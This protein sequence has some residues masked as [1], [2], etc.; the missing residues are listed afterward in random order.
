MAARSCVCGVALFRLHLRRA[1]VSALICGLDGIRGFL[2]GLPR[3]LFSSRG[4]YGTSAGCGVSISFSSHFP[5]THSTRRLRNVFYPFAVLCLFLN[6]LRTLF[7]VLATM[8]AG[9]VAETRYI[10]HPL[11]T[12]KTSS[13]ICVIIGF[14]NFAFAQQARTNSLLERANSEIERLSQEAE[15]ER[16]ALD[17]HDLLGHTLTVITVKLDLARR[18]LFPRF[19]T[20]PTTRLWKRS[21]LL[22]MPSPKLEKP[23]PVTAP[24]DLAQRS[25]AP[26]GPSSAPM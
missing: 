24:K 6:R 5:I 17:L 13:S 11:I 26:G 23:C 16:I 21:R 19:R 20:A 1:R 12:P 3:P 25:V 14:T 2:H 9:V 7:L 18:L 10:G 8:M 4:A 22:E 15:R